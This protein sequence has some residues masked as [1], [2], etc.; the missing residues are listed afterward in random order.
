MYFEDIKKI[1]FNSKGDKL[2]IDL[3]STGSYSMMIICSACE[4]DKGLQIYGCNMTFTE[5][6]QKNP[7]SFKFPHVFTFKNNTNYI[8]ENDLELKSRFTQNPIYKFSI[9]VHKLLI[10]FPTPL[11]TIEINDDQIWCEQPLKSVSLY[12]CGLNYL[13]VSGKVLDGEE[14]ECSAL[15]ESIGGSRIQLAVNDY[16]P[17]VIGVLALLVLIIVLISIN[18]YMG[19]KLK[20]AKL[21]S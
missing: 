20:V 17:R 13:I 18:I 6:N 7:I 12:K 9:T 1:D 11:R 14:H 8:I 21:G 16:C 2:I 3:K 4:T 15:S 10:Q 5:K 19:K